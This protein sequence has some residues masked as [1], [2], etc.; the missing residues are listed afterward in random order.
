MFYKISWN[1]QL[2]AA[3][4]LFSASFLIQLSVLNTLLESFIYAVLITTGFELSKGLSIILYRHFTANHQQQKYPFSI[5]IFTLFF[6]TGLVA[7]SI[8]AS[9][10]L[11]AG[12]LY[13]PHKQSIQTQELNNERAHYRTSLDELTQLH[14]QEKK[15]IQ[16]RMNVTYKQ[17]L[18]ATQQHTQQQITLLSSALKKEMNNVQNGIFK[19]KRYK[20]IDLQL[21]QVKTEGFSEQQAITQLHESAIAKVLKGEKNRY[22]FEA[23]QLKT[24]HDARISHI[25]QK[26]YAKDSR[27]EDKN[28]YAF[29]Q[30]VN[31]VTPFEW[32][33]L[34]V[35]FF[36]SLALSVLMELG[37]IIGIENIALSYLP[38]FAAQETV[39]QE[40]AK[41]RVENEGEMEQFKQDEALL[42]SKVATRSDRVFN[43]AK[44]FITEP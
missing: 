18:L 44:D 28:T 33:P 31:Q 37:I 22:S 7:I 30:M 9:M 42:R 29:I 15:A 19:G 5:R 1:L 32:S 3:I 23:A 36:F 10:N 43:Q 39:A 38:I 6:R 27:V 2:F 11:V 24:A 25:E 4:L 12:Y 34:E 20:E 35:A 14:L 13:A 41:N 21:K 16:T 40:V 8:Y 17:R 26:D